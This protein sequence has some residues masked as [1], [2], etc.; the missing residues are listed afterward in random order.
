MGRSGAVFPDRYRA[1]I[2]KTRR[3]TRHALS[4]VLNN[5]R[6]HGEDRDAISREWHI[7]PYS[8][9]SSFDGWSD[10]HPLTP[11]PPPESALLVSTPRSWLLRTD[12]E[13]QVPGSR[14]RSSLFSAPDRRRANRE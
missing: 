3:G 5:W 12:P 11:R 2:I 10:A 4:Y 1:K 9:A 7:N 8:S 13:I 14:F 6:C